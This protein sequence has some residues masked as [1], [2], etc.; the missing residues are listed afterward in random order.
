MV[1][2]LVL[3]LLCSTAPN[4][5]MEPTLTALINDG[6]KI[7]VLVGDGTGIGVV[8]TGIGLVAG[9]GIGLVAGIDFAV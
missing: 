6:K 9:T 2:L 7:V 4:T 3:I 8:G 5:K 1:L